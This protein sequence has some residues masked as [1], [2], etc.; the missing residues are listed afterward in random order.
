[1][2]TYP[3]KRFWNTRDGSYQT[4]WNGFL[5]NPLDEFGSIANPNAKPFGALAGT[6]FLG[7]L[8]EAGAGKT[9]TLKAEFASGADLIV[10]R[11]GI[12]KHISLR[13]VGN[14]AELNEAVFHA[15]WFRAWQ[16]GD[17]E[18]HLFLDALDEASDF[19]PQIASRFVTCLSGLPLQRLFIRI[20]CRTASWP[21]TFDAEI[22]RLLEEASLAPAD[23]AVYELLPLRRIDVE[24]AAQTEGLGADEFVTEVIQKGLVPLALK[25]LTLSFLIGSRLRHQALPTSSVDA[26]E[27]GCLDLAT[28]AN[29]SRLDGHAAG[30]LDAEQR[31]AIAE[32]IAAATLLC[33]RQAVW[34]GLPSERPITDVAL[35][36]LHGGERL[37]ERKVDISDSEVREVLSTGLFSSRGQN[38][39]GWSHQSFGEFLAARYLVRHGFTV[40]QVLSLIGTPNDLEQSVRPQLAG[41]A[42]WLASMSRDVQ[43]ALVE[44][45]P[46]VF[47]LGDA[48]RF[49]EDVRRRLVARILER[50]ENAEFV[51]REWR[52]LRLYRKLNY[53]GI[54]DQ[55]R[56]VVADQRLEVAT[57][58]E[59]ILIARTC[60]AYELCD[61][62]GELA[63]DER[64]PLPLRVTAADCVASIGT[65]DAKGRLKSLAE[66]A[67]ED[68]HDELKAAAL[69]ALWP[70]SM[71]TPELLTYLSRRRQPNYLGAYHRF[72][73][74]VPEASPDTDISVL[75]DWIATLDTSYSLSRTFGHIALRIF[76]RAW[77]NAD[78]ELMAK[79]ARA[80]RNAYRLHLEVSG[81]D[82]TEPP[83]QRRLLVEKLA[84][85]FDSRHQIGKE[86][87]WNFTVLINDDFE[88][89]LARFSS[90]S[91]EQRPIWL[92]FL[93]HTFRI[94]SAG[95]ADLFLETAQ[96]FGTLAAEFAGSLG[97][98]DLNSDAAKRAQRSLR[99][100]AETEKR[101]LSSRRDG[102]AELSRCLALAD[103]GTPEAWLSVT[104][105]LSIDADGKE[106]PGLPGDLATSDG[107]TNAD[108]RTRKRILLAATTFLQTY[109]PKTQEWLGTNK[110]PW[111]VFAGISAFSLLQSSA[112]LELSDLDTL[113]WTRWAPALLTM[114]FFGRE[115]N[116]TAA[117]LRRIAYAKA[118]DVVLQTL[119]TAIDADDWSVT[120]K[121]D[122]I[123]NYQVEELFVAK[124]RAPSVGAGVFSPI[125]RRLLAHRSAPAIQEA[126]TILTKG[127]PVDPSERE[128]FILT[129]VLLLSTDP[130]GAW[131]LI[132]PRL[133]DD[134][135]FARDFFVVVA[136]NGRTGYSSSTARL[137]ESQIADMY[138]RLCDLFP[139]ASNRVISGGQMGPDDEARDLRDAVLAGLE[140]RGTE[141]ACDAIASISLRIPSLKWLKWSSLEART[142]RRRNSALWPR[143]AV[144]FAMAAGKSCRF[145]RDAA[146]L[147]NVIIEALMD[148]A[149]D[150]RGETPAT[151][152][153]WN[154]NQ[155]K[156][157]GDISDWVKRH[158]ERELKKRGVIL[159]RENQ[160]HIRE[161]TDLHVDA[162]VADDEGPVNTVTVIVEVKGCWNPELL[163]AMKDQLAGK[164]LT[165][166][167]CRFGIYLVFWFE[168]DAWDPKDRRRQ[169]RPWKRSLEELRSELSARADAL[170]DFAIRALVLD[171]RLPAVRRRRRSSPSGSDRKRAKPPAP[172]S[173]ARPPSRTRGSGSRPP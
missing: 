47:L 149:K 91:E 28:E 155:P 77:A 98:V 18:L 134:D 131:P 84:L 143:P 132:W 40:P 3:W 56:E 153:L 165:N 106:H 72:L 96:R 101:R 102:K 14:A 141:E 2:A 161:K 31:L 156:A 43:L 4:D 144:I 5:A 29:P 50:V 27:E 37:R 110:W 162:V 34:V 135:E 42:A 169:R 55:L 168:C 9:Q 146:D 94:E 122:E 53:S 86:S 10:R 87:L 108:P 75:L 154:G 19:Y 70:E 71:E 16:R 142:A 62:F 151:P 51:D 63:L 118:P 121:V 159:G 170:S 73:L 129:G 158:L 140:S 111:A 35:H 103:S 145:V 52:F 116:E 109:D 167:E 66:G 82:W 113:T 126:T 99:E 128:R 46:E 93:S 120:E 60:G 92:E 104:W 171:A 65:S 97:S 148:L 68:A 48:T 12:P 124:L 6:H 83:E 172:A 88:W 36:D 26:F 115:T 152:D 78:G 100:Q 114:P 17:N 49:Q 58:R 74:S 157:E 85:S 164:Y 7:L 166:N 107:W 15:D 44:T 59:A 32:R 76:S 22:G 80:L 173:T 30:R 163:T 23:Y 11:G 125:L 150:L 24:M 90:A 13:D 81:I 38:R 137:G 136:R 117:A 119:S 69:E 25:P 127:V 89:M 57:R 41:T 1:M 45:D 105:A 8:G 67:P 139:H 39:F 160:I 54:A 133:K 64:T 61:L 20:T 95:Q 33:N 138:V 112:A 147:Q 79:L 21:A 123:W 130:A